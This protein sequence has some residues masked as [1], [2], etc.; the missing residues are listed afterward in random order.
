ME[1]K[2][3]FLRTDLRGISGYDP[4]EQLNALAADGWRVVS[5]A[6]SGGLFLIATLARG[7]DRY[8]GPLVTPGGNSVP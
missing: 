6:G 3:V 5:T 7:G 8:D 1:Y 2:V 4:E